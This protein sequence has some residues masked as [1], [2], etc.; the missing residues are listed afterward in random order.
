MTLATKAYVHSADLS[1]QAKHVSYPKW[2]SVLNHIYFFW[3][4]GEK[5]KVW[6]SY[7]GAVCNNSRVRDILEWEQ[8]DEMD[9]WYFFPQHFMKNVASNWA[10]LL[11]SSFYELTSLLL[12][13]FDFATPSSETQTTVREYLGRSWRRVIVCPRAQACACRR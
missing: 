1:K 12:I 11:A 9:S 4:G 7:L 6:L 5:R 13:F 8:R 2:R 10:G 3:S